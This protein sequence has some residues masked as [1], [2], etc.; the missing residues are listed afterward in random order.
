MT[1][2]SLDVAR[3]EELLGLLRD[4]NFIVVFLGI[5]I[6]AEG[7]PAGDEEDAERAGGHGR[8]GP[9]DPVQPVRDG[10]HDRRLRPRRRGIFEEQY[11]FLQEARIPIS[12]TGMLN[13]VPKTP[14]H[15][16]LKATGRL[17]AESVGDQFVFTNIVPSGMSRLE[18]YEGYR[19]LLRRLYDYRHYRRRAMALILAGGP[20]SRLADRGPPRR[21]RRCT[22]DRVACIL[23][24]SPRRAW[25]TLSHVPGDGVAPPA[26]DPGGVHAGADAQALLRVCARCV[27]AA[28]GRDLR[29]AGVGARALSA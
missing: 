27:E 12:M 9:Q 6:A 7:E 14:L 3:D 2:A 22:A 10:G 24:A 5:E 20:G 8:G 28:R 4:A 13:A 29:A 11:Q 16:R 15:A 26:R 17:I 21:P 25:L 1:E 23:R 19:A 18:L